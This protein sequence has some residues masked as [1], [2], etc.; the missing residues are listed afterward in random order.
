MKKVFVRPRTRVCY[1][2]M[3]IYRN[4]ILRI[5]G[6]PEAGEIVDIF[7]SNGVYLGKGYYNPTSKISLR[8]VTTKI[9]S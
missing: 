2:H 7:T 5:E 8:I 6:E 3:W 1:G 9:S 4:D